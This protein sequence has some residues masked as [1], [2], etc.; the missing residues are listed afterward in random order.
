MTSFSEVLD[1]AKHAADA[2]NAIE[3]TEHA[4]A[5]SFFG[6]H[7]NGFETAAQLRDEMI[8]QAKAGF[9]AAGSVAIE[10]IQ[11][12][13]V[14]AGL[15]SADT[16]LII[17]AP[18]LDRVVS[19]IVRNFNLYMASNKTETDFRRLQ[20]RTDLS[21]QAAVRRGFTENQ[22]AAAA[23]LREQGA[24]LK[25]IWLANFVDNVPCR[26]C[27]SLHGTEVPLSTEFP[28]GDEKSAKIFHGLQGPPR[29]PNCHCYML[30]YVITLGT[31]PH[32]PDVPV[33]EEEKFMS[34]KDVRRLPR[35]V[36][37]AAVTTL[38]LIAGK[39]K[40][41]FRGKR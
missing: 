19:D 31:I 20:F 7:Q 3:V 27:K 10:H 25:K 39:L 11:G 12:L 9:A 32:V 23:V 15:P 24:T 13:S 38:R 14:S 18:V 21:V 16:P 6:R 34:A 37:T 17:S 41:A 26:D 35:S 40:G 22:L 8:R 36:Y 1:L 4:R 5:L 2:L 28:H 33:V 29:H 30:V